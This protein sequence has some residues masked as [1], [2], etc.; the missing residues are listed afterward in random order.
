MHER[1]TLYGGQLWTERGDAGFTV[2]ARLPL[3]GAQS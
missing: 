3:V 2:H 1:V